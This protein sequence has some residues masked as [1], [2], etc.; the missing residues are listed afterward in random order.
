MNYQEINDND[1]PQIPKILLQKI[2][3]Y[4]IYDVFCRQNASTNNHGIVTYSMDSY[5]AVQAYSPYDIECDFNAIAQQY[6]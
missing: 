6:T 4:Q 3:N 1:L 2:D 5:L